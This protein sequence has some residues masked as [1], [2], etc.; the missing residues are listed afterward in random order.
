MTTFSH[1]VQLRQ[2]GLSMFQAATFGKSAYGKCLSE[3]WKD[4][5]VYFFLPSF[6]SFFLPFFF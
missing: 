4:K 6:L 2:W 1:A 5:P 3:I